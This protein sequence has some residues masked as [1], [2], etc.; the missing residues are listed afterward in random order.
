MDRTIRIGHSP[1][2]DDAFMFHA[3]TTQA[4][5]TPGFHYVHDLQDIQT[6]NERAHNGE[7][8]VSAISIHSYPSVSH[9][10]ALMNCGA[11][12]GEGYGPMIVARPGVDIE[13]IRHAPI[14]VPGLQIGSWTSTTVLA[15]PRG[16]VDT[17][18]AS[19]PCTRTRVADAASSISDEVQ[20]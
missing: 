18:I 16:P 19:L 7:L 15:W 1:D 3:L 11:S 8:E 9:R 17:G 2:P 4:F 20:P 13:E 12:M 14:A 6:L 5:K 10:Y